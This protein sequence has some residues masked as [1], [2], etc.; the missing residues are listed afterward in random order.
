MYIPG[1][2][3]MKVNEGICQIVELV[4][5]RDPGSTKGKEYYLLSPLE[6]PTVK[7]YVLVEGAEHRIRPVMSRAAA[8]VLI[9]RIRT[10]EAIPVQDER[11]RKQQYRQALHSGDPEQLVAMIKQTYQRNHRRNQQGKKNTA[12]DSRFF[13]LAEDR[14]YAELAF[15]LETDRK[16][17]CRLIEVQMK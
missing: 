8:E 9:A 17:V 14:L 16:G 10:I 11:H 2:Y 3:V 4:T 7:V 1:A 5:L 6:T 15:V 12:V 13:Q